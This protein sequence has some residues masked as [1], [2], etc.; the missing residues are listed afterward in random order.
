MIANVATAVIPITLG[1]A[2]PKHRAFDV[3]V[4]IRRGL[5]YLFA[6]Q[7]LRLVLALPIAGLVWAAVVNRNLPLGDPLEG[8][9][10]IEKRIVS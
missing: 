2:V 3:Q 7:V 5:Q 9:D 1:Y 10:H 6:R 4:V 8:R